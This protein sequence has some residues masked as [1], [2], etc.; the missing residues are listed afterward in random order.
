MQEASVKGKVRAKT[1]S[2]TG[3]STLSG[4][5]TLSSGEE[6]VFSIMLSGFTKESHQYKAE[7]EDR[8]CQLLVA[9]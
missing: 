8:I 2:M 3:I 6:A 5:A 1:G 7:I 4:Y 9:N